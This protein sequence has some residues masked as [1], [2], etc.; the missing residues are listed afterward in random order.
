MNQFYFHLIFRSY[1]AAEQDDLWHF[2]TDAGHVAKVLPT[3]VTVKNI[4]DTWTLQTGYPVLNVIRS[5]DDDSVEMKQEKFNLV[6]SGSKPNPEPMWWIPITYTHGGELIF[7]QTQAKHWLPKEKSISLT[8]LGV[9]PNQW[10][11]VNLQETGYY[12]VN[13][14][15][16]NWHL[17]I[18]HLMNEKK[19]K[20]IVPTN[21]AQLLDDAMSLANANYLKYEIAL[22]VTRYLKHEVDYVPLAAG[23]KVLD[24]L[25]GMLY[26]TADY[27]LF[28]EY[29]LNRLNKIYQLVGF[30]DQPNSDLLKVY[31]RMDILRV[32]C[33]LGHQDCIDKSI[34]KFHEWFH[35]AN[36]D[37]NNKISANIRGTV[38]CTAIK[39]GPQAYWD[40]AWERYKSTNVASE[41]EIL[42]GS[43]ACTREPWLLTRFMELALMTNS[44]IRKQD[45]VSVFRAVA[46][47][48]VGD[49]LAFNFIRD[50]W[51]RIKNQ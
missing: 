20:E 44:E 37:L 43:L 17:L 51:D 30:E 46:S 12:R 33:H 40:F 34:A 22:N 1:S 24:F 35:E 28:K 21:R 47:N 18:D 16:R 39:Y 4:M 23:I 31:T 29:Y 26:N 36:P 49:L 2:L 19:F 25:D 42:L 8:G 6:S 50:N 7:N 14:D 10:M 3:N 38:Y 41:K 11:L 27:N 45:A 9:P 15:Y 5:Y 32:V 13:Y 48:S